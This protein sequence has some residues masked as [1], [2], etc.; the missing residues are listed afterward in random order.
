[1]KTLN[2]IKIILKDWFNNHAMINSVYYEDAF[3]YEAESSIDYPSVNLEFLESN[4]DD[5]V[6][7]YQIQVTIS[8]I[9]KPDNNE[10]EDNIHSDSIQVA[11]DFI[12]FLETQEDKYWFNGVTSF[13]KFTDDSG[14]RASGIVFIVTISTIRRL[15]KCA[16]PTRPS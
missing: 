1:M 7:N 5:R 12:T 8:D 4:I 3:D 14:D 15:N 10:M 9:T 11:E 2:E 13:N 6:I 16:T